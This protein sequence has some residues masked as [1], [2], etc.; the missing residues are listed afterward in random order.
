MPRTFDNLNQ[1]SE[2]LPAL[3]DTF[4]LSLWADFC[5]GYLNLRGWTVRGV[6]RRL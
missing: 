5:V 6:G 4:A 2:L 1:D 3:K